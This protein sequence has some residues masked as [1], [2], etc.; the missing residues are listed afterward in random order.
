MRTGF[1]IDG[2][3]APL[4]PFLA[5]EW[6]SISAARNLPVAPKLNLGMASPLAL[7]QPA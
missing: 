3:R 6:H 1:G 5:P 2:Q 7:A 4:V